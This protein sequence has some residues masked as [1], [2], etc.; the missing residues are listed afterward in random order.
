MRLAAADTGQPTV[1]PDAAETS[2]A[3]P[4]IGMLWS[5]VRD[6]WSMKSFARHD[7]IMMGQGALGLKPDAEPEGLAANFTE[8]SIGVARERIAEIKRLN[9]RAVILADMLFYEYPDDWLPADHPWWLRKDGERLQF[10]PGTH[11]MDWGQA[12]YR[13]KVVQ[14]TVALKRIG[15]DG[16]FYDNLRDEPDPWVAFLTEVRTA[17]GEDFLVLANAG[18]AVG[19]YDFA[20]PFL[21]GVMYESGWS[22]GRRDW[23]ELIKRMQHTETLL[24]EPRISL[25]E[26]FE[27]TRSR[28][29][30]PGDPNRGKKPQAD[31]AARRWS[32]SFS[33]IVGDFYYLFSDSTSHKHDWYPEYDNKIGHP[34]SPPRQ[35]NSH[36]WTRSYSEGEVYVNLPGATEALKVSVPFEARDTFTGQTGRQFDVRPGDGRVLKRID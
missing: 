10:W 8:E 31:P 6:D 12:E 34:K 13:H 2:A 19:D 17:V 22:H 32:L 29:G 3:Y 36:A 23:D 11:R 26:R 27:E 25:I 21:N 5:P 16:V 18:Y 15:V 9:P 35:L 4:R 28:A 30:W 1:S 33:L 14:Q 20:A 7:L 24:R